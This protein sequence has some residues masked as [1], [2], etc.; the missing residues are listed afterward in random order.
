MAFRSAIIRRAQD[1]TIRDDLRATLSEFISTLIFVFASSGSAIAVNNFTVD[2]PTRLLI[3][4]VAHAFSLF[5]AVAI[6]TNLS[7]GHVNPAV[8]L[9]SFVGGNLTWLRFI[10]FF[11]AQIFASVIACLLLRLATGQGVPV[12]GLSSGVRV[13]NAVVLEMVM[14]FGLV[15][16]VYATTVDPR[17]KKRGNSGTMTPIV[18]GFIVGANI[19][20]GGPFDG[21]SMNPAASFGP[22]LV[23]W[24]WKNHWVYWVG[25]L[26]GGG[27]AGFLY[28]LIFISQSRQRF[29]RNYYNYSNYY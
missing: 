12:Y 25:P 28:E 27:L 3:V 14:T 8:T 22:A 5:V 9:G 2:A 6:S 26:A 15:Y 16:A 18:I 11:V 23:G 17:T 21:A 4:A 10:L 19:M 7:G 20:V 13:E 24:K 29:R 1:A